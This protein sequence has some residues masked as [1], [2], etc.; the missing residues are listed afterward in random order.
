MLIR[1]VVKN[2]LD[3]FI[4]V[5]WRL[6]TTPSWFHHSYSNCGGF[7]SMSVFRFFQ[8]VLFWKTNDTRI[9]LDYF[10]NKFLAH[11]D[12]AACFTEVV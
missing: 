3:L 1:A 12:A 7:K 5:R 10:I 6:A 4:F 9:V 8:F 11:G 2:V